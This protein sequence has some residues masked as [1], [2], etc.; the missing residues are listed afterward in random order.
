MYKNFFGGKE[1]MR[2]AFFANSRM[3]SGC[4]AHQKVALI[5]SGVMDARNGLIILV[6]N[7][8]VRMSVRMA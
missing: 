4:R 8:Q 1:G 2:L 5:S 6:V 7:G 3:V